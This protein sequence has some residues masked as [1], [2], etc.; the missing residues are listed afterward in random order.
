MEL[1]QLEYVRTVARHQSFTRAAEEISVSQS[2]LSQ[3]IN[4]LEGE[5]GIRLFDR[6]TRKVR[7][8]PAGVDFV[9]HSNNVFQEIDEARRTVQKYLSVEQG[10]ITIGAF[11]AI[12]HYNLT[13]LIAD[14]QKAFPGV[15]LSFQ[16]AECEELAGMLQESK[17]DIAFQSEI[18]APNVEFHNL[19]VDDIALI[20]NSFHPLATQQTVSLHE[21]KNEKIIVPLPSSGIYQNLM[22]AC[23]EHGFSPDIIY[24]CCQIDTNVGL[25]RENIGVGILSSRVAMRHRDEISVLRIVPPIIR[26]ISLAVAKNSTPSPAVS[27]FIKFARQWAAERSIR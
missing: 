6:T 16:E 13:A 26:K 21:L 9:R 25:V 15:R 3:Q 23:D 18:D 4:K 17:V 24:H 7:L 22:K 14:F 5:L 2:S 20:V 1:H 19:Y 27:V 8:T 10:N 11:P 12:G